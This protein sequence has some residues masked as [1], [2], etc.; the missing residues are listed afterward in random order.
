ME[1]PP[2]D[3]GYDGGQDG[4]PSCKTD[5][6]CG[7]GL[8]C[9]SGRC[10]V[11]PDGGTQT[12]AGPP[13]DEHL[14]FGPPVGS[15]NYVFV[16]NT[17]LGTVAKIDPGSLANIEVSSIPVGLR[18]TI[19]A[20]IPGSDNAVVL[21][22]GSRSLSVIEAAEDQ[23][24]VIDV[25]IGQPYTSMVISPGGRW[26]VAF[27]DQSEVWTDP[28]NSASKIAVVDIDAVLAG[29][30][31]VY[32]F[33][34]GYRVT[35]VIFDR[36]NG[37]QGPF[38]SRLLIVSKS[39]IAVAD[40]GLLETT[41]ILPRVW[42][43]NPDAEVVEAREVL[44]TPDAR[45]LLFRNF[46]T[47]ELTV[48]DM[49]QAES[50]R[51]MLHS[52]PTDVDLSPDGAT[53]VAVQRGTG[54]VTRVDLNSDLSRVVELDGVRYFDPDGDGLPE[55]DDL[56]H[57]LAQN[58]YGEPLKV[59]QAE[60][61][62]TVDFRLAAVL[63]TNVDRA[64]EISII[65][66]DTMEITYLGRLINKLVDYVVISPS[67]NTAL[68]IHRAEYNSPETD[69]VE[70]EIDAL[71]GYTLV[72]LPSQATF[73]Q[74]IEAPVGPLSFSRTGR[75]AL[76]TVFDDHMEVNELHVVDLFRLTLQMDSVP[77]EALPLFV[78]ALPGGEIGYVA[79]EHDYGKITF[80]DMETM[81]KRAVTGYEL[82]AE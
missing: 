19:L 52:V 53:L 7:P 3:G 49:D 73:Q 33:A 21:N 2:N 50:T 23:D 10:V 63:Y 51:L 76:L 80:V 59:G 18:P 70:R 27:F 8:A 13:E 42:I 32:E 24:T 66:M 74:V 34:V 55:A 30:I 9:Q 77:L 47:T 57:V 37:P 72:D 58:P 65:H 14:E 17:T 16:V 44:A 28:A 61:F 75:Y 69:P 20:T 46:N 68:V 60:L 39:E 56:T 78:G 35:D 1:P 31:K 29:E 67:A 40:L 43:D 11:V 64:E 41:W 15:E 71:Y 62:T 54:I 12:D 45:T 6:D 38:A 22:E 5:Q 26:A 48:V 82:N 79:Q 4:G 81:A 25:P 36:L